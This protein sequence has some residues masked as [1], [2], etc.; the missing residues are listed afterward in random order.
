MLDRDWADHFRF[1]PIQT[2]WAKAVCQQYEMP[3]DLS[4]A[5]LLDEQGAHTNSTAVLRL[6][7]HLNFPFN[8]L[9]RLGLLFPIYLRDFAYR[10][11]AR[12]RGTVWRCL[13]RTGWQTPVMEG[14]RD[15]IIGLEPPLDPGWGFDEGSAADGAA[16]PSPSE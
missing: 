13:K 16:A 4:T 9:G 3:V 5:V 7:P 14:Y 11:F 15:R 10:L 12:N 6:F 2:D 1:S 8:V